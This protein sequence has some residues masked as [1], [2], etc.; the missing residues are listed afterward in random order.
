[1]VGR[2]Q[3]IFETVLDLVDF[4]IPQK[5]YGHERKFQSELQEY[6]DRELNEPHDGFFERTEN[7]RD[8]PVSTERGKSRADV[9]VDD[10]VGIELKR[11][12]SNRQRRNLEGQIRDYL[13]E[14]PYVIV[15]A[16]GIEDKDGWRRLKN[17]FEGGGFGMNSG[18]VVFAHKRK[19]NYGK[20][21]SEF[22]EDNGGLFGGGLF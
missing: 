1:M 8:L 4:W 3:Q 22:W 17:D 15:C 9:V 20:D 14:Y 2:D 11:E 21:P 18:E 19:E 7:E 13:D 5:A 6:L 12:L 16:C 10:L